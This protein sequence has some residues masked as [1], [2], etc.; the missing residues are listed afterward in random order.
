MVSRR[1]SDHSDT[2]TDCVVKIPCPPQGLG[3]GRPLGAY[4]G[5][6]AAKSSLFVDDKWIQ[7]H[8][9]RSQ[10]GSAAEGG[11]HREAERRCPAQPC[12]WP[13]RS[14]SW[15]KST[16]MEISPYYGLSNARVAS[17]CLLLVFR[18]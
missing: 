5:P 2:T 8:R 4:E 6:A 10:S 9:S 17:I 14:P 12:P 15:S 13:R 7:K 3:F 18:G 11:M 16:E 1:G